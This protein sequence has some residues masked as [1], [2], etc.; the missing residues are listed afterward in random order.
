MLRS[1]LGS[2]CGAVGRAVAIHTR[3]LHFESSHRQKFYLL[4]TLLK[5]K[6]KTKKVG[7][8]QIKKGKVAGVVKSP[9]KN[10]TPQVTDTLGANQKCDWCQF[11]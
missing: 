6:I 7:N 3:D 4:S 2:G 5:T 9:L 11:H 10:G 8:G 1:W